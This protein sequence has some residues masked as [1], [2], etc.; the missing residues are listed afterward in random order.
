[1]SDPTN[2]AAFLGECL[3]FIWMC[4]FSACVVICTLAVLRIESNTRRSK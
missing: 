3:Y 1:M 4:G 2:S